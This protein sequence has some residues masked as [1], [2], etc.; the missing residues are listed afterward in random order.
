[1]GID[2]KVDL[3]KIIYNIN[4]DNVEQLHLFNQSPI[5]L[6]INLKEHK[7]GGKCYI[8]KTISAISV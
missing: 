8:Y 4:S 3:E 5:N 6:N 1:M 2:N 7:S